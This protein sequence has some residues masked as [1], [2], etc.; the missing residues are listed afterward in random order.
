MSKLSYDAIIIGAGII[1]AACAFELSKRG[2]RSLNVDKLPASGYGSTSNSCAII[3][4]YYST[5]A[6][7]ALAYGSYF[8]WK[9]WEKYLGLQA[10]VQLAQFHDTGALVMKTAQNGY[11][12]DTVKIMEVLGVPYEHWDAGKI[13]KK[14]SIFDLKHFAPA[15]LF[16]NPD[17]GKPTGGALQGGI[18]FP[19]GGYISDPQLATNNL[20]RASEQ[21]GAEFLFNNKVADI[22]QENQSVKG[23]LLDSGEKIFSPIVIN[24]GGP[25][26]KKINQMANVLADMKISTKALK[27]EVVHVPSPNGF[28]FE[29][30]GLVVSDSDIACYLRPDV[31]NNILI[32]SED[33]ECDLREEVDPDNWDGNF[34]EQWKTQAYRQSQRIPSLKIST[35]LRG[36][37]DLYDVT[38]DWAPI[39][40]KSMLKG[41]YMAIGTSGNQFKNAP[42]VGKIMAELI[43]YCE[44]GND[45]D[46]KPLKLRLEYIDYEL[47][48]ASFS[49]L[50]EIN[51]NSSFSVLG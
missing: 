27:Q 46:L 2:W 35:E 16:D 32:G 18:F 14:L 36:V 7:S 33:P 19:A 49:R 9:D 38:Q 21:F 44:A 47:D 50:R 29:K 25:H 30:N 31:G 12:E 15:K 3:R 6:S 20:Q 48:I 5:V 34:T 10:K 41:Y 43:E 24:V 17:F 23:V 1:G 40:D 4:A 37:V 28:D 26:S 45:H 22:I 13:T 11:L 42:V 39:Y 51:Q 8:Y